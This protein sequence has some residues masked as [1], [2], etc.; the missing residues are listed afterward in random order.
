[1][2]ITEI[3][4]AMGV[5]KST[6]HRTLVTL[7]NKGFVIKCRRM[8]SINTEYENLYTIGMVVGEKYVI[9]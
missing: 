8:V 7:E 3:S 4:K 6:V 9:D 1:M 2:G 5:Y